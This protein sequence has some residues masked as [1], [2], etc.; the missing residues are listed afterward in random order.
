MEFPVF[1][2]P[3]LVDHLEHSNVDARKGED[4]Q[5]PNTGENV[6]HGSA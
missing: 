4:A 1:F 2:L 5:L 6:T 3:V